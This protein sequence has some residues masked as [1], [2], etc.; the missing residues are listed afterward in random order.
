MRFSPCGKYIASGSFDKSVRVWDMQGS[1]KELHC[2][3]KH[4]LNVSDLWW[5]KDSSLLLSGA[6]DQT[7]KVWS[8]E[9]GKMI[10][11]IES[12]GFVQCVSFDPTSDQVFFNGT[13][14]NVLAV[15]DRRKPEQ[16]ISMRNDSMVNSMYKRKGEER[17]E[18]GKS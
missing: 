9:T 15:V 10:E 12:E 13:S 17:N 3:K 2:L 14:R 18:R 6:Y 8:T 7:C 1:P 16:A 11:S 5:S 4:S